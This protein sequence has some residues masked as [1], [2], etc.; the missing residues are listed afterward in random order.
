MNIRDCI[1][2]A[3]RNIKANWDIIKKMVIGESVIIILFV[4]FIAV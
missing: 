4:C 1:Q 3:L 2:V